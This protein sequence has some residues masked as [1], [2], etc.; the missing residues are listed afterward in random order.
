MGQSAVLR[1]RDE[2]QTDGKGCSIRIRELAS[3]TIDEGAVLEGLLLPGTISDRIARHM[4]KSFLTARHCRDLP[5]Q[6]TVRHQ[7]D[8]RT[9]RRADAVFTPVYAR[10]SGRAGFESE[11]ATGEG[12]GGVI[13]IPNGALAL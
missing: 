8:Q 7:C 6:A 9:I 10:L 4:T 2:R 12:R 13:R 5:G 1:R 11:A 3:Q